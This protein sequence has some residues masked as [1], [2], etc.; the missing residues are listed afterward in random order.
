MRITLVSNIFPPAVG[1][2]ATHIYHLATTLHELG[3]L[4]RV[5]VCTGDPEG[6]VRTP[7]PVARIPWSVPIP[8]RYL[9]VFW[10]TW[11]AALKSDVVYING[12]ELP[13]SLG[14]VLAG[15]PRVLKVVGDWAWE[16]A[17]RRGL[18]RQGLEEFRSAK[19]QPVVRVFQA[20]Q[21]LYC[22]LATVVVVPSGYVGD[23]V[24]GWGVPPRK[25]TVIHNALAY[26]PSTNLT[27]EQAKAELGLQ[28]TV[29]CNV[30]RLYSWKKVDELI[31]MSPEFS[32]EATLVIVGDGPEQPYLERVAADSGVA[33][34]VKFVGPQ[35]HDR[36]AVYLKA[37]DVFVLNTRYE[38]LSHTLVEARYAGAPIVTT[39]IGGNREI[40]RHNESALLVPYGDRAAFVEAVNLLIADPARG[41]QLAAK[42]REGL[43]HFK[44][45]RL[46]NETVALLE[47]LIGHAKPISV[48][49]HEGDR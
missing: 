42:G 38:G 47:R 13:S 48:S 8:V 31:R 34:R 10:R 15:K 26:I 16:S 43:D 37:A 4:V 1:G 9:R 44:W 11:R 2:P 30:S 23:M 14:A 39:D 33:D 45:E 32:N 20:I 27:R 28:G 19:Q 29:V 17:L 21:R 18:S 46:A 12:V 6:K 49:L 24:R 35:S 41:G 36:V 3:H 7:F 22:H 40:L 5:I 25:I